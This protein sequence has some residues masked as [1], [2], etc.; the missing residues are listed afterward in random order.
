MP[1]RVLCSATHEVEWQRKMSG[2]D[3]DSYDSLPDDSSDAGGT[4]TGFDRFTHG[5]EKV[6]RSTEDFLNDIHEAYSFDLNPEYRIK[7][8]KRFPTFSVGARFDFKSGDCRLKLKEGL[9]DVEGKRRGGGFRFW[10][11][12]KKVEVQPEFGE[13]ELFTRPLHW[14]ILS[15][16]AIGGYKSETGNFNFRYKV[17]S[18]IWENT[19]MAALRRLEWG[20]NDR[21]KGAL[22]WDIDVRPPKAEGGFGDGSGSSLADVDIGSYH[23]AVPRVEL[24]IDL[25]RETTSARAARLNAKDDEDEEE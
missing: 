25:S 11:L 14:G 16:Q 1:P 15:L 18:K 9:G 24:K 13:V 6:R 5:A 19:A 8:V 4:R 12:F 22:R 23:L 20:P 10:R 7:M 17:T 3:S 21:V 2:S